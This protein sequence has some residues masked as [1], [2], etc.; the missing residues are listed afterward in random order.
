M[1]ERFSVWWVDLNPTKG[2]EQ[3]GR[4]PVLVVSPDSMNKHLR[5]VLVA[6]MTT[7]VRGWPSRVRIEHDGRTGE[8]ALDQLRA[9]DKTRLVRST[10][11]LEIVY[12][13]AVL[14]TLADMFAE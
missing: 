6:P 3:A 11:L 14:N 12:H 5:T 10:G 2:S 1:V 13:S 7:A 4:R 9:V 8:V